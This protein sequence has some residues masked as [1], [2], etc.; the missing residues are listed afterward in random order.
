MIVLCDVDGADVEFRPSPCCRRTG[1]ALV[2]KGLEVMP[3]PGRAVEKDRIA[4]SGGGIV[5]VLVDVDRWPRWSWDIAL[6]LEAS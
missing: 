6:Y 4:R 3:V 5:P 2:H 1:M